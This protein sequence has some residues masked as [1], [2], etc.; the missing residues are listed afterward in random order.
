MTGH[1]ARWYG[2]RTM[3]IEHDGHVPVVAASA[4]VAP[5][6]V[7][8]GDVT[9]EGEASVLFGAVIVADGGPVRIGRRTVVM[10]HALLRGR[11]GHPTTVGANVLIGP[12]AHVNGA[13]V[14]D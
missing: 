11:A 12:N 6:A 8:C 14:E 4:Y 13:V 5:T 9:V 1:R 10:E 7:L 2:P 3:L